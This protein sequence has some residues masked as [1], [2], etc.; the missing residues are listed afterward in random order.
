M[1][2]VFRLRPWRQGFDISPFLVA[3]VAQTLPHTLA[4]LLVQGHDARPA[5]ADSVARPGPGQWAILEVVVHLADSDAISID[6][7]KRMLAEDNPP[8]L[9]ADETGGVAFP[10]R[11]VSI[12]AVRPHPL[13]ATAYDLRVFFGVVDRDPLEVNTADVL[14]FVK[15]QRQGSSRVV[16]T[17]SRRF[18]SSLPE[19]TCASHV[20]RTAFAVAMAL[21][22]GS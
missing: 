17:C 3:A 5:A 15:A 8:L 13:L 2:A 16:R 14:G 9:Y 19:A 20:L 10:D 1:L 18:T 22:P 6:R 21:L 12:A 11:H 7:M 4:V